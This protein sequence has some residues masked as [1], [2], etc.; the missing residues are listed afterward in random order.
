MVGRIQRYNNTT[1]LGVGKPFDKQDADRKWCDGRPDLRGLST[2][3][4][5][6]RARFKPR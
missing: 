3:P 4:A 1:A 2:Y 5:A 6:S